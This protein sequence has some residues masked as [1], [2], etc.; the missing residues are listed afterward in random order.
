MQNL[1]SKQ[2]RVREELDSIFGDSDRPVSMADLS[3]L[4][5]LECCIEESLRLFPS[6]PTIGRELSQDT[7]IRN[8]HSNLALLIGKQ[9]ELELTRQ[10]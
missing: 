8:K 10:V 1:V 9:S 6:V 4:K 5:Y 2:E 7:V 3:Q